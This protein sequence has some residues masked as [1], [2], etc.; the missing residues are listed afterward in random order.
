MYK[1]MKRTLL[2]ILL[3]LATAVSAS[4]QQW[5]DFSSNERLDVGV[6]V[7]QVAHNTPFARIGYGVFFNAWGFYMDFMEAIPQHRF[8]TKGTEPYWNDDKSLLASIGYQIPVLPW[9]K[10][11]PVFGYVQTSEGVTDGNTIEFGGEIDSKFYHNFTVTPGS[12]VHYLNYGCGISL[13]PLKWL[14]IN[15]IFTKYAIYGG[16]GIN[17]MSFNL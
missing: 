17:L 4:A 14:S 8:D 11:M 2:L 1:D 7:G 5:F 6:N 15:G 16:I 13:Q 3:T 12:R 9:V 10:V